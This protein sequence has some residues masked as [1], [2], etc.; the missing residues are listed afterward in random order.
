[1]TYASGQANGQSVAVADANGDGHPDLVVN[2]GGSVSVL[3]NNGD[4]TFPTLLSYSTVNQQPVS[5]VAIADVNGDGRPDLIAGTAYTGTDVMLNRLF[6]LTTTTVASSANPSLTNQ[7]VTFTAT[8]SSCPDG[9]KVTFYDAKIVIGT[10]TTTKGIANF[11]TTFSKAKTYAIRATYPGNAFLGSSSGAVKKGQLVTL[12]P[13]S[14]TVSSSPNP[15]TLGQ[16]VALTASVGSNAP[17]GATG[18]VIF[19][20]GA[21]NLGKGTVRDGVATLTTSKLPIGTLTITATYHGDLQSS[22]SS[23]TTTQTVQ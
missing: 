22:K 14:T 10:A 16:P 6:D 21:T 13:S 9:S 8:V 5:S 1:M 3:F 12:Y 20:N 19:K 18:T 2:G 15:S 7:P 11:T 23:G 17:G 4:G